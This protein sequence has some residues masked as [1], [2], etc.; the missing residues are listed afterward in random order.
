MLKPM[1]GAWPVLYISVLDMSR[2]STTKSVIF[3]YLVHSS[4][5]KDL[6]IQNLFISTAAGVMVCDGRKMFPRISSLC[7]LY[8]LVLWDHRVNLESF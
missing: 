2:L 6:V 7:R 4:I 8:F 1:L 5:P 3:I